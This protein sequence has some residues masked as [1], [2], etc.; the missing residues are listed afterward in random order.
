MERKMKQRIIE[1]TGRLFLVLAFGLSLTGMMKA[2]ETPNQTFSAKRQQV[3]EKL[4]S[5]K[6]SA[7]NGLEISE[8][9]R[10]NFDLGQRFALAKF[11]TQGL[12]QYNDAYFYLVVGLVELSDKLEG[13]PES[14][15]LQKVLKS[16]VR[17]EAP[18]S[19]IKTELE[20][21]GNQYLARQTNEQQWYF[22]SGLTVTGVVNAGF[23][24]D[25][26]ELKKS[27]SEM[28]ALI[29]IAPAGTPNELL[30]PMGDLV[31]YVAQT[32]FSEDDFYA[33]SENA[34]I[35]SESIIA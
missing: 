30:E 32:T 5:Q 12:D 8:V 17:N 28:Q 24:F 26:E 22:K 15:E 21:I 16:V 2:N 4:R 29:K 10:A 27:L 3:F 34:M 11:D 23:M 35:I 1:I 31:K 9:N 7:K 25:E 18:S 33:I 19:E 6:Q 14:V 20:R 13:S